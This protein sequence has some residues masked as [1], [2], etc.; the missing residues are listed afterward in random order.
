MI[1]PLD[2]AKLNDFFVLEHFSKALTFY[3]VKIVRNSRK[4]A[5]RTKTPATV[6][7]QAIVYLDKTLTKLQKNGSL[8]LLNLL[9]QTYYR[10]FLFDDHEFFV[11]IM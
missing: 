3:F 8:F 4:L 6:G 1:I 7:F 10:I 9:C 2:G 5:K 11:F